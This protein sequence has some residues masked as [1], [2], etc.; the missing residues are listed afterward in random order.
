MTKRRQIARWWIAL[1]AIP[2][3]ALPSRAADFHHIRFYVPDPK[4]AAEWY[5]KHLEG[6]VERFGDYDT[7]VFGPVRIIFATSKEGAAPGQTTT[8]IDHVAW[9]FKDAKAKLEELKAAGAEAL[10][11]LFVFEE[12]KFAWLLDPWGNKIE[13]FE[14]PPFT[15]IHKIHLVSD[16]PEATFKR[17]LAVF[18]GEMS[19]FP[20]TRK[21]LDGVRYGDVWVLATKTRPERSSRPGRPLGALG[22]SVPDLDAAMNTAKTQGAKAL[23]EPRRFGKAKSVMLESPEGI[24]IEILEKEF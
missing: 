13:V 20:A 8:A 4:V 11:D 16:Q 19:K 9:A 23:S 5:A 15:G 6:R 2:L 21:W 12:A 1:L 7:A 24:K 22:W 17:L 14:D 10:S 3:C 18:G